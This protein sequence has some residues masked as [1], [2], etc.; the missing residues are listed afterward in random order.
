VFRLWLCISDQHDLRL[1]LLAGLICATTCLAAVVILRQQHGESRL[2]DRRWRI[3][4]GI[5]TGFGIWCTHFVAMLGYDSGITVGYDMLLTGLS[6]A[7]SVAATTIG[8]GIAADRRS[9]PSAWRRA[10]RSSAAA[11]RRCII[12][13]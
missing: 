6:L 7:V 1:L 3:V 2:V 11:R 10:A 8:F 4:A 13:A 5:T 12:S 9:P